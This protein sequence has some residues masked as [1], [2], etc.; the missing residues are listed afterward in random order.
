[1]CSF[2]YASKVTRDI[3]WDCGGPEFYLEQLNPL[4]EEMSAQILDAVAYWLQ[5]LCT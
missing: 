2:V 3:L 1:M 5:V 4:D